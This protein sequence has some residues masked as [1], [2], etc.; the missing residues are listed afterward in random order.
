MTN[1]LF[2]TAWVFGSVLSAELLGY[3]L[4]RLLHSGGLGFLSRNHMTHHLVLYGPL[5]EQR[6]HHYH[7]ATTNSVSL[8]NIGVEWLLP[9][10]LLIVLALVGFHWLQVRMLFQTIYFFTTLAW[11]FLMFSYLH[12][13]MH[14]EGFWLEQNRLLRRWFTSARKLHDIHHRVINND[15]LM[16]TNFGIGFFLFD[17]LFGT[18]CSSDLAFNV[19]GFQ[20]AKEKFRSIIER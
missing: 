19:D 7:D 2:S 6:S 4:H 10:T 17:R 12:D 16:N 8:G 15:G 5:Q 3:G 14:I 18:I 20:V 9:S 1:I 11:G 13:V